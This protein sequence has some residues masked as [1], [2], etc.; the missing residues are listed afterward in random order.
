[1]GYRQNLN[2]E[3]RTA[4][5][6]LCW[7]EGI[8]QPVVLSP[9]EIKAWNGFPHF[10]SLIPSGSHKKTVPVLEAHVRVIPA[11]RA[12]AAE[13]GPGSASTE[14]SLPCELQASWTCRSNT[15]K[16]FCL[17]PQIKM[18]SFGL[19]LGGNVTPDDQEGNS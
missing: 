5:F 8:S 16:R 19:N 10:S 4:G 6:A 15:T 1:M 2:R 7:C 11:E 9:S 17:S 13:L 12:E 18:C 14:Q 3:A